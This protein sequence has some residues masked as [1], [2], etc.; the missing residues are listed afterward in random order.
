MS[1]E[2]RKYSLVY[3]GKD[4]GIV[5][6][7]KVSE[8]LNSY[9][10]H[11]LPE[12]PMYVDGVTVNVYG[13]D[14][15]EEIAKFIEDNTD[16]GYVTC[17]DSRGEIIVVHRDGHPW[18]VLGYTNLDAWTFPNWE[19]YKES[20]EAR[21]KREKEVEEF[22]KHYKIQSIKS[23]Q[24]IDRKTNKVLHK[25]NNWKP[26]CFNSE[27]TITYPAN[28]EEDTRV[29]QTQQPLKQ[30][31]DFALKNLPNKINEPI[32]T[33]ISKKYPKE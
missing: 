23:V 15:K 9:T 4:R 22:W 1:Y 20:D 27:P 18:Y 28:N 12:I 19:D 30:N 5:P 2:F 6:Y 16:E 11:F 29:L 3:K 24:I 7:D 14:T 33:N 21:K 25:S 13:F 31:I 32:F 10:Y 26:S 8:I 17:M